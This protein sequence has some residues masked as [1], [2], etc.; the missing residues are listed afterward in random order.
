[1]DSNTSFQAQNLI[2]IIQIVATRVSNLS[3][4]F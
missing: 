4:K 3:S 2:S 1:M